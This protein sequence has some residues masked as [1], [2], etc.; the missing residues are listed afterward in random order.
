MISLVLGT[1]F[2]MVNPQVLFA[3]ELN[4]DEEGIEFE[5]DNIGNGNA[6]HESETSN[7]NAFVQSESVDGVEV[8][9]EAEEGV[10]PEGVSLSVRKCNDSERESVEETIGKEREI[11]DHVVASYTFDIKIVDKDGEEIEPNGD[12]KVSFEA[13]EAENTNLRTDVYHVTETN[14]ASLNAEIMNTE[15]DG[16]TVSVVTDGFSYYTVEFTYGKLQYVMQGDSEIPLADIL[17]AVG[18]SG[19]VTE[20]ESSNADLFSAEEMNGEWTVTAKQAFDTEEWLKVTIDGVVY[21]IVVTDE[22]E[23]GSLGAWDGSTKAVTE[24]NGKYTITSAAELDWFASKVN[25]GESF[26]GKTIYITGNIDLN[27]REWR[28]IGI[29]N[30]KW[31]KGDIIFKDCTIKNLLSTSPY[32]GSNDGFNGLFG[33]I[34]VSSLKFENTV[35]DNA[36]ISATDAHAGIIASAIRIAENG[37][38]SMTD[39]KVTGKVMGRGSNTLYQDYYFGGACGWH[40]TSRKQYKSRNCQFRNKC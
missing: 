33:V 23:S 18:L 9:V 7:E 37:V 38:F 28:K 17:N 14:E 6:E 21:E 30:D 1:A 16:S 34:K 32:T 36:N 15:K 8:T 35:I 10:F 24:V 29:W 25:A 12:V 3:E 40:R 4:A 11:S 22:Q 20:A 39:C 31:I 26:Q 13:E 5:T 19:T 27:N 2:A